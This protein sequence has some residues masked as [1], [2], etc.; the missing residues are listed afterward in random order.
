[1]QNL[2]VRTM[3]LYA[4]LMAV[5]GLGSSILAGNEDAFIMR[6]PLIQQKALL[7]AAVLAVRPL[8]IRVCD[9]GIRTRRQAIGPPVC[10]PNSL[11]DPAGGK[12]VAEPTFRLDRTGRPAPEAH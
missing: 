4:S 5:L 6:V 12:K 2:T 11:T 10:L 9:F 3:S 7:V 8:C 1:M